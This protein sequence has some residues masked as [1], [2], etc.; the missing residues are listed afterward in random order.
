MDRTTGNR[1]GQQQAVSAYSQQAQGSQVNEERVRVFYREVASDILAPLRNSP[2]RERLELLQ[3]IVSGAAK[4][5]GNSSAAH[6]AND[7]SAMGRA[8]ETLQAISNTNGD[9]TLL[10][11][12]LINGLQ[13]SL[14]KYMDKRISD[15]IAANR[16]AEAATTAIAAMHRAQAAGAQ[17]FEQ[18]GACDNSTLLMLL[19]FSH[20]KFFKEGL[21]RSLIDRFEDAKSPFVADATLG[22][23]FKDGFN[24]ALIARLPENQ[25]AALQ[26]VLA[27]QDY[28]AR[29]D[30]L[31]M[32][33]MGFLENPGA[34]AV[35]AGVSPHSV[36]VSP[37]TTTTTTSTTS[38]TGTTT[39]TTTTTTTAATDTTATMPT[40][41]P[42]VPA[43]TGAVNVEEALATRKWMTEEEVSVG[44]QLAFMDADSNIA[45]DGDH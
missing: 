2:M 38:A 31:A 12:E 41:A 17:A 21:D 32:T 37:A 14:P 42:D 11:D 27:E 16:S 45:K 30:M 35:D 23:A 24:E 5:F 19:G 36:A 9:A 22:Y 4:N 8:K 20:S 10:L 28:A 15:T 29:R 3:F 34:G 44:V 1:L 26:Q 25:K 43:R 40:S 39:T 7:D 13:V 33:I 18:F 6:V